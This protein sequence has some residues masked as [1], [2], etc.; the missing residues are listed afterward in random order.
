METLRTIKKEAVN[1]YRRGVEHAMSGRKRLESP[2]NHFLENDDYYV[3]GYVDGE[4]LKTLL[5]KANDQ[6]YTA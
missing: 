6:G 1:A 4:N 2:S 5:N 3:Q